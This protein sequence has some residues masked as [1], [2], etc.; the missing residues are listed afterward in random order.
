MFIPQAIWPF[1][2]M[3]ATELF[4]DVEAGV[5]EPMDHF[6]LRINNLSH[7]VK[8]LLGHTVSALVNQQVEHRLEGHRGALI[9]SLVDWSFLVAKFIF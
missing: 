5:E 4:S 7:N 8:E 6:R 3:K 9:E 2:K 1:E